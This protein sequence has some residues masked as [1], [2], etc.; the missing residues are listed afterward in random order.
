M[1]GNDRNL[2]E[3]QLEKFERHVAEQESRQRAITQ[4]NELAENAIV[5][6]KERIKE[7]EAVENAT[8]TSLKSQVAQ[9]VTSQRDQE[10]E[11]KVVTSAKAVAAKEIAALKAQ[12]LNYAEET[13]VLKTR[14]SE[15]EAA[16][17]QTDDTVTAMTKTHADVTAASATGMAVAEK[18]I[19]EWETTCKDKDIEIASLNDQQ[20]NIRAS[21]VVANEAAETLKTKLS[22]LF[23]SSSQSIANLQ[24]QLKDANDGRTALADKHAELIVMNATTNKQ[25]EALTAQCKDDTNEI[26]VLKTQVSE[27]YAALKQRDDTVAAMTAKY[28]DETAASAAGK[29]RTDQEFDHVSKQAL[30]LGMGKAAVEK[31]IEALSKNLEE[32]HDRIEYLEK[33][34]AAAEV[35]PIIVIYV[36]HLLFIILTYAPLTFFHL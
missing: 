16:L 29:I 17:K 24:A 14:V 3:E 8:V 19:A 1:A 25:V 34:I 26:A 6:L 28:N 30:E 18:T 22:A 31:E 27:L 9:L 35:G 20:T 4:E 21:S 7:Q 33:K 32:M 5:V 23:T 36:P 12:G 13:S 2:L 11:L 15:L 10:A